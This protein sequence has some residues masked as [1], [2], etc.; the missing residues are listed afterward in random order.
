MDILRDTFLFPL[1]LSSL[2]SSRPYVRS[3]GRKFEASERQEEEQGLQSVGNFLIS[4]P[5]CFV[6]TL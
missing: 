6:P 3:K 4:A 5:L 1:L 2:S